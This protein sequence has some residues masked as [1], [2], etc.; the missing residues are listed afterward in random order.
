[1]SFS[2]ILKKAISKDIKA[3]CDLG[4]LDSDL[5]LTECGTDWLLA[6]LLDLNR[7]ELGDAAQAELADRKKNK[8]KK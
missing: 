8:K 7:K 4:Y 1:M 5:R 6:E 3:M 2:A